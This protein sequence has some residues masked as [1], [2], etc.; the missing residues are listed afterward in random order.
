[1]S[2]TKPMQFTALGI[3]ALVFLSALTG[4]TIIINGKNDNK[5]ELDI[6]SIQ[7]EDGSGKKFLFEATMVRSIAASGLSQ[8][9]KVPYK[10]YFDTNLRSGWIQ[11]KTT[12]E[13]EMAAKIF[14]KM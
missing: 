11:N 7:R 5:H 6:H 2:E 12:K 4:D 1:M 10:G 3:N 8:K 14:D 9:M 13:A